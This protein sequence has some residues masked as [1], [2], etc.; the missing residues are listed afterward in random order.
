MYNIT[1]H[2]SAMSEWGVGKLEDQVLDTSVAANA[3]HQKVA[4]GESDRLAKAKKL[5]DAKAH[6]EDLLKNHL[7]VY[8]PADK[9]VF[10]K[11]Y[12]DYTDAVYE[13][14]RKG[15]GEIS[16]D[17]DKRLGQQWQGLLSDTYNS[18]NTYQQKIQNKNLLDKGNYRLSEQNKV[19]TAHNA[20]NFDENGVADFN[21]N[22]VAGVPI[23]DT[24][25]KIAEKARSIKALVDGNLQQGKAAN[26][27]VQNPY[28]AAKELVTSDANFGKEWISQLEDMPLES[29][30]KHL[31]DTFTEPKT[32]YGVDNP[33]AIKD[34][35][36]REAKK[37]EINAL[38]DK[39]KDAYLNNHDLTDVEKM[40]GT[41]LQHRMTFNSTPKE[42]EGSQARYQK[43]VDK[44]SRVTKSFDSTTG[45]TTV[46]VSAPLTESGK[47]DIRLSPLI[48]TNGDEMKVQLTN[49]KEH[50][51]GEIFDAKGLAIKQEEY[52][53][54]KKAHDVWEQKSAE[55]TMKDETYSVPEPV[56]HNK[57]HEISI[58]NKEA[59]TM[60]ANEHGIHTGHL[61]KVT[62]EGY[63]SK[64]N[65]YVRILKENAAVGGKKAQ[66]VIDNKA[67]ANHPLPKGKPAT[68]AQNGHT[69]TWSEQSGTYE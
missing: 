44:A 29:T 58:S 5:A 8:D 64:A 2:N 41:E 52:D 14:S 53:K 9:A 50:K 26:E 13:E 34:S 33:S 51:N 65:A 45:D 40:V 22:V 32:Q 17:A 21:K 46:Y 67:K 31:L 24:E 49:W 19:L 16:L 42:S 57:M 69:Y 15:G 28:D 62:K 61:R 30:K 54:Y 38:T 27:G 48:N 37:A 1:P 60:A 63:D 10:E 25:K 12:K 36:A 3:L 56:F 47:T 6:A 23:Y 7:G 11:R 55:A 18:A 39:T 20:S 59:E 43:Q 68:I 4:I 35:A 66:D